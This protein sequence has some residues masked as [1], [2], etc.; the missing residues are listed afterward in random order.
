MLNLLNIRLIVENKSKNGD[1]E[2]NNSLYN[3]RVHFTG[4]NVYHQ[5]II[6]AKYKLYPMV[7][8]EQGNKLFRFST[9]QF[10]NTLHHL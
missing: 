2:I 6:N 4:V 7:I 8:G 5:I 3:L 9:R 1:G 10:V